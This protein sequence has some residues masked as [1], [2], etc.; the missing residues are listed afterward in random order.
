[1]HFCCLQAT[2]SV[3]LRYSPRQ[4]GFAERGTATSEEVAVPG[5]DGDF[6]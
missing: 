3:A 1:M 5:E 6:K 4:A 2:P